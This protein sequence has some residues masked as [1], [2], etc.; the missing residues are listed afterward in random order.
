MALVLKDR[1]K[2]TSTTT[3]T[4]SLTL[5]G[6]S[7]G[8]QTFS[9]AIGNTN[10]T[11]YTIQNAGEWEVGIGTVSAGSLSRDTV[12]ASS[13]GAKVA[14][15]AGTKDVFCTYPAGKS[16]YTDASGNVNLSGTLTSTG[17]I[18]PSVTASSTDL[19]LSAISTG[20]VNLNTLN[21]TS[22]KATDVGS[23]MVN[24]VE[25]QGGGS[26]ARALISSGGS[27]GSIPLVIRTK[28]TSAINFATNTSSTNI[29]AV[30]AHTASA[31][32][33][34]QVTGSATGGL[35]T[36]SAQGSDAAVA[37]AIQSKGTSPI[38]LQNGSAQRILRADGTGTGVNY[39]NIVSSAASQAPIFSIAAASSDGN[40]SMAFQPKGT[41]AIDLAAGSNGVNISNGGTVTAVTRT[42]A[43]TGY[44]TQP[45]WTASA[46]TTA[47]GTTAS[48]TAN[49][50]LAAVSSIG[51][52]GT[53]YTAG[54][55]LTISGGTV[56]S[57][58]AQVTVS[59]VSSGVI[60]AVTVTRG[61]DYT[62]SPTNPASVTGG[63]G[64]SAT[65]N[66]TFG[67]LN[68]VVSVAGSGYIE[69]PTI[70]FSGGGGSS[71]A[72]YAT[73]GSGTVIRSLGNTMDLY[74][75]SGIG[76]RIGDGGATTTGYWTAYPNTASPS[77]RAIGSSSGQIATGSAVPIQ[78]LT[79]ATSSS[80][81]QLRV[82]HT[83]SAVNYVQVTGAATSGQPTIS[84]QGSDANI[85]LALSPKG[86]GLINITSAANIARNS[87][88]FIQI[89]GGAATGNA[90]SINAL[91][92]DP[93]IDLT[94][95]PKGTGSVAINSAIKLGASLDAGTSGYVMTSAGTGAS[96]TWTASTAGGMTLLG[97][98]TTT[99]GT[100][101]SLSSLVLT[102]YKQVLFIINGVSNTGTFG[103]FTMT[104]PNATTFNLAGFGGTSTFTITGYLTIDL[105]SGVLFGV[106]RNNTTTTFPDVNS[107]G[108]ANILVIGKTTFSTSTTT[109]TFGASANAFD[110]GSILVYGIK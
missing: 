95:T 54:D 5:L 81:E 74:A 28:G 19:T 29:Q 43:G 90:P 42:N 97:T 51:S 61:G 37:L 86:T 77:L 13:T 87:Y 103:N 104:D 33:Y 2:E 6:A 83:A 27:D 109:F 25:V 80:V 22:L 56:A 98:I 92:T 89:A 23:S 34:V 1:V 110:A 9:S 69:Q 101:V 45:T 17:E 102:S 38:V 108:G 79:N 72:A 26:S 16:V 78:F 35:P 52:G 7:T 47:G 12:L 91:G 65:F 105:S 39:F 88:N 71:A 66:L 49:L 107:G 3:G 24:Y 94:L 73:V 50:V 63:T 10:T 21:G 4:G 18:T 106:V 96:P 68:P 41:G 85:T 53:G 75:P 58:T 20:N 40:V 30:V 46:P 48:G 84:P 100:S 8:Y 70:T 62:A 55:V 67:I 44:T 60:T 82:S 64:S 59:T 11:Y 14:L 36:I 31:V 99:S 15:S 76:F 57:Q 93:N 32:N